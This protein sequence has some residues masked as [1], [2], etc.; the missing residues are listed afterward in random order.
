VAVHYERD[1]SRRRITIM[2]T[3]VVTP[4]EVRGALDRQ[5]REGT[6]SYGVLY[7]TRAA[8]NVPTPDDLRELVL[9]VGMLTTRC[10]PRG[11]VALIS[12]SREFSR[13]GRAYSTLGELTALDVAVFGSVDEAEAWL[14][15]QQP[16]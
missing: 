12:N 14:A 2:T 4:D 8:L 7:D 3:G 10:G 16:R 9:H 5:A 11:P 6:W 15:H 1:D 13:L